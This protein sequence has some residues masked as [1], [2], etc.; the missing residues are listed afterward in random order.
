MCGVPKEP[1]PII[2]VD[3]ICHVGK[4]GGFP[5]PERAADLLACPDPTPPRYHPGIAFL[6]DVVT[7]FGNLRFAKTSREHRSIAQGVG[8]KRVDKWRGREWYSPQ[9]PLLKPDFDR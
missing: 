1:L 8:I 3:L 7:D 5:H 4:E 2:L 6:E 9:L